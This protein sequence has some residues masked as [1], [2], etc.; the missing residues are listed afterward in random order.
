MI[1]SIWLIFSKYLAPSPDKIRNLGIIA[2]VDA[3]KTTVCER[4]LY[5]SGESSFLGDVDKG[6][7][8][9]DYMKLERERGI[10]I[11]AA[12][13][14]FQWKNYF[15]NVIDTPGHVD[16]TAE[17]ERSVSVLDGA[18]AIIDAVAGVQAQT[19]TV[20]NQSN[21]YNIPRIVFINKMDREGASLEHCIMSI[22]KRLR[23]MPLP[24][25]LPFG[26]SKNFT[27]C[28]DIV[29]KRLIKFDENNKGSVVIYEEL[30]ENLIQK[31][32]DERRTLVEQLSNYDDKITEYIISNDVDLDDIP[33]DLIYES[34][35]RSTLN[36][37]IVPV[38]LG[39]ALKNKGIQ[40]LLDAII[41]ILPSP[42]ES[43]KEM[44]FVG[45][46]VIELE[47]NTNKDLVAQ[48]FKVVHDFQLGLIVY[49]RIY[50]GKLMSGTKIK[51]S[52]RDVQERMLRVMRVY[53]DQ[54]IDQKEVNAGDICAL[55]GLKNT[56]TGDTLLS[57]KANGVMKTV[58]IPEPV[59]FCS[60]LADSRKDEDYLKESLD[61]L[62]KE[63]P[64]F[65]WSKNN[66]TGQW[67][68][69]GMGELHLEILK[70]R[71]FNYYK[72][73]ATTGPIQIAY[74][75]TIASYIEQQFSRE[76]VIGGKTEYVSITLEL[77][78]NET[79]KGVQFEIDESVLLSLPPI[80]KI[81]NE[82][83]ENLVNGAESTLKSGIPAGFPMADIKITVTDLLYDQNVSLNTYRLCLMEAIVRI[84][85]QAGIVILEPLMKLE[86]TVD[87]EYLGGI[88]SDLTSKR[89]ATIDQVGHVGFKK[90]IECKVPLKELE[91][92]S[93]E[94]R[95]LSKGS[96]SYSVIFDHYGPLPST[97]QKDLLD[98]MGYM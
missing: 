40:P 96:A 51:N 7:T 34:V 21:K 72:A 47:C 1:L 25:Q 62:H 22:K 2:H 70:H 87:E 71:L 16:F 80:K 5:Y 20:W 38:F 18:V 68:M 67:L 76:Y 14:T 29:E 30:P 45:D 28:I 98:S 65:V 78:P 3:G 55:T 24:L 11:N 89:R 82:L 69:S 64:S 53:A 43:R 90:L 91:D 17:V 81:K 44:L 42:L 77:E 94:I 19:E 63:D 49:A 56:Y 26:E 58:E 31:V 35:K 95:S 75:S 84:A 9:M 46:D 37:K 32:K 54:Y 13:T 36:M 66:E 74:K 39:S 50:Q 60:I 57:I 59:Y 61:N 52:T 41:N 10:T 79:G 97:L 92:Y 15:I 23:A 83:T 93:T 73:K 48:A 6:D 27:G 33:N 88:L 86:I 8:V 85:M 12:A 4:M